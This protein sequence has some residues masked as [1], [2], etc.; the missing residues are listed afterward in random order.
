MVTGLVLVAAVA[1]AAIQRASSAP[2]LSRAARNTVST[3]RSLCSIC[4]RPAPAQCICST[5]PAK[6]I[7]TSTR[8]LALQHP[9]EHKKRISSVPLLELC[10]NP[11][12]VVRGDRFD[13][14]LEPFARAVAEGYEPVLL[15]PSPSADCLDKAEVSGSAAGGDAGNAARS[16]ACHLCCPA[17]SAACV[18]PELGFP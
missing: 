17:R 7:E 14:M 18:P 3:P 10:V 5:L 1:A 4:S 8:M 15:F 12:T 6:P 2:P 11:V 13:T 9:A 16:T